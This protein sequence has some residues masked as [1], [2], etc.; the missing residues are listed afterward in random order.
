VDYQFKEEIDEIVKEKRCT[1]S[2]FV[3]Q[4]I[5]FYMEQPRYKEERWNKLNNKIDRVWEAVN[6]RKTTRMD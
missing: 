6:G 4:S 5:K 2:D 1:L 3:R